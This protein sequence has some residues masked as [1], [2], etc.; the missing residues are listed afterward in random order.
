MHRGGTFLKHL[1]WALINCTKE[2][3]GGRISTREHPDLPTF[4]GRAE[5]GS[6]HSVAASRCATSLG[7]CLFPLS[8]VL[9][10]PHYVVVC[11]Q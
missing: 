5:E 4:H 11:S 10:A 2:E 8:G 1:S 7:E 6:P 3:K 9:L